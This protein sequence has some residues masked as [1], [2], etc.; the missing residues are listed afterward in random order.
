MIAYRSSREEAYAAREELSVAKPAGVV[1]YDVMLLIVYL[2]TTGKPISVAGW[3]LLGSRMDLATPGFSV[4]VFAKVY[5]GEAGPYI[6][7]WEGSAKVGVAAAI[8]A[9]SGCKGLPTISSQKASASSSTTV[10]APTLTTT[11][12]NNMLVFLASQQ[13]S[14]TWT[15]P[16]SFTGRVT[17]GFDI[18]DHE[19]AAAG[20]SGAKTATLSVAAWNAAALVALEPETTPP[21][22]K[23]PAEQESTEGKA[24]TPWTPSLEGG[25][26]KVVTWQLEGAPSGISI[27]AETG[28]ISGTPGAGT[29]GTEP[30]V[31]VKAT[32][33]AGTASTSFVWK[34][35]A[36]VVVSVIGATQKPPLDLHAE[37]V[38]PDGTTVRWD[39][40]SREAKDRPTG[41]SFRTQRYT[42]FADAQLTLNRRIDLDYPDLDLLD[43][44]NLVGH[45]GSSAYEGTIGSEPRSLEGTPQI[46]IQAQGWMAH[47]KDQ[48]FVEPFVDRDPSKWVS[49]AARRVAS[50]I[51]SSFM[52]G[53]SSE[54]ADEA[55]EQVVELDIQGAW[56][57]PYKPNAEAWWLP[58]AGIQIG[59][60]YYDFS[61]YN[62]ATMTGGDPNWNVI[63]RLCSDDAA[64]STDD[65]ANL[66]PGPS[67][68]YLSASAARL[69][70]AIRLRY[71]A[72][73]AGT[74]GATFYARFAKLAVYGTH[75]LTRRGEDPGGLYVSDMLAYIAQRWASKLDTSGI[76]ATTFPVPHA[77]FLTDIYPYDA[78]LALNAYHRWELAVYEKRRLLYYPIDLTDWDWE[79]RLSDHGTGVKLQGDD[80]TALANGVIVRYQDLN[81]GYETRLHPSQFPELRDENP[82]NPA[83]K[84]GRQLYTTLPLSMPTTQEGAI[85]MGRAYLAEFNQPKAPGEINVMGHVRDRAGHWQPAWKVRAGD[86]LIIS[87]L[88]N[89]RVRVVGETNWDHD[90]K[91]LRIA[92]ESS[93]KQ[94]DAIMARLNVALEA[95]GLSL[96]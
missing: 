49:P 82:D 77:S 48:Q 27:N 25:S 89:D 62:T 14:G 17:A 63:A 71:N 47:A 60:L 16:A 7:E 26:G 43:G 59:A 75:G 42:G 28:E 10:E 21:A 86:R 22:V 95:S 20:A 96:P 93:F 36:P 9:Y 11:S 24:I 72:T 94:L 66:Y 3:T 70:A 23:K 46:G 40:D 85:Q 35:T 45:D 80:I 18:A 76:Q 61:A 33:A 44:I 4:A 2:E 65:S 8:A 58:Q 53:A 55:G 69:A 79:I 39:R 56:A 92:V 13:G 34:V 83:N 78:F 31:T 1:H 12:A 91:T 19:Q 73:P 67:A 29:A 54:L 32:N 87:D 15:Q 84:A 38:Y 41:M 68:G 50:L 88:P 57:S 74:Q 64:S 52:L 30:T 51:S 5:E 6:V 37:L 90:A 81:T